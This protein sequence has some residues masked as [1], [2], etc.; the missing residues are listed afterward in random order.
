MRLQQLHALAKETR[1]YKDIP[2][3][4]MDEMVYCLEEKCLL[5]KKGIHTRPIAHIHDVKATMK[6]LANEVS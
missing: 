4:E 6:H 3:A 5:E 1:S 2:Q